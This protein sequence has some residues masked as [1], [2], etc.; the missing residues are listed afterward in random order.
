MNEFDPCPGCNG[1]ILLED[2]DSE[3]KGLKCLDCGYTCLP[4]EHQAVNSNEVLSNKRNEKIDYWK[5]RCEA[6]ESVIESINTKSEAMSLIAHQSW[7][8]IKEDGEPT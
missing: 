2:S 3:E 8:E 5:R 4:P 6:A 7:L 1:G